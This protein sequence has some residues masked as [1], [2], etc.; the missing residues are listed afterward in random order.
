MARDWRTWAETERDPEKAAKLRK[1]GDRCEALARSAHTREAKAAKK[2]IEGAQAAGAE[3]VTEA[4]AAGLIHPIHMQEEVACPVPGESPSLLASRCG[5]RI[6]RHGI[7]SQ[8][9]ESVCRQFNRGRDT[10]FNGD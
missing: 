6:P 3:V 2:A 7:A 9:S 4:A 8:E 5:S 10:P 1:H